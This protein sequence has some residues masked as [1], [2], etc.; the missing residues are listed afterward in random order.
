MIDFNIINEETPILE[1]FSKI[2]D[3]L[4]QGVERG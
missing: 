3:I 1:A 4:K 2:D